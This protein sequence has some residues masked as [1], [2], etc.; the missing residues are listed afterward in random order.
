M[1][2][3]NSKER[4]VQEV[5]AE[6]RALD[7]ELD[8]MDQAIADRLG[9]NRTDAQCMDIITRSGPI[10]AGDLAERV[11]LTAG[12]I[13]TVLD[14]LE[15]GRWIRRAHDTVDRRR[16]MVCPNQSQRKTMQPIFS[17]LVGSTRELLERYSSDELELIADF[18]RR[19]AAVAA[20]HR[21]RMRGSPLASS[22]AHDHRP[23][24]GWA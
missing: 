10:S 21:Q 2:S 1:S 19:V 16:V 4:L 22:H 20:E 5:I 7:G 14:R 9:L 11:G 24:S 18:L 23:P 12:A 8:L 3:V 13:T 17:R 6:L 15:R